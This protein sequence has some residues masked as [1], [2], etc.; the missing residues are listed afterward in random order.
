MYHIQKESLLFYKG[1]LMEQKIVRSYQNTSSCE[2]DV[3]ELLSKG[4]VVRYANVLPAN[5][6]IY[7]FVEYVLEKDP[8]LKEVKNG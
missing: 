7:G 5:N 4:W 1:E 6:N 3:N 2:S 8:N